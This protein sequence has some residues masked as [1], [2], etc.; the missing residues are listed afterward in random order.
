MRTGL[1]SSSFPFA[2]MLA[3]AGAPGCSS[4]S[5]GAE[6]NAPAGPLPTADATPASTT[7]ENLAKVPCRFNVPTTPEG[8]AYQCYDLSVPENRSV[9]GSRTIKV[10]AIVFRGKAGG[11]PTFELNG[12]PGG[13]SEDTAVPL[14]LGVPDVVQSVGRF[15][16]VGDYVLIDQRGTGRSIPRIEC[17]PSEQDLGPIDGGQKCADRWKAQGADLTGYVTSENAEDIHDLK[18]ALGASRV[19]LHSISYGTRLALEVL[20]RHPDDVARTI[21]DGVLPA[22]AKAL[23][24]GDAN[25]D[26][27]LTHI[28]QSCA[29]DAACH[30]AYPD[31]DKA[32]ADLKAKLDAHP[33][34][35][36]GQPYGWMDWSG[37]LLDNLYADGYAGEVPFLVYDMLGKTDAQFQA[38]MAARAQADEAY[39]NQRDADLGATDLGREVQKRMAADTDPGAAEMAGGMYLSVVCSD[40]VQYESLDEALALEAKI[41]PAFREDARVRDIWD[42]CKP[43]PTRPKA[44]DVWTAVV[45]DQPVLAIGGSYDPATP[46]PWRDL[47]ASTLSQSEKVTMKA[48]AHGALDACAM[49]MKL[50]FYAGTPVDSACADAQVLSFHMPGAAPSKLRP[51]RIVKAMPISPIGIAAMTRTRTRTRHGAP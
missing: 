31:P 11:T 7:P 19:N 35:Y 43:W 49:T 36:Q 26:A 51:R 47:A 16:E 14:A 50:A 17:T 29:A 8:S 48:G 23:T 28:F 21:I 41:R 32:L 33:F 37:E 18:V 40:Y 42:A 2:M 39:M 30:A 13:P 10:H 46:V 5:D 20:R 3:L 9:P 4:A 6:S 25:I 34:S 44:A 45:S 27:L 1:A 12:G 38:D 15:L 24:E 22:Q